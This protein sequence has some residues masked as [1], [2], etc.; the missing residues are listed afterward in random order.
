MP[1]DHA[2]ESDTVSWFRTSGSSGPISAGAKSSTSSTLANSKGSRRPK[3]ETPQAFRKPCALPSIQLRKCCVAMRL[4]FS[5][6]SQYRLL[7]KR[8]EHFG[9]CFRGLRR[10]VFVSSQ[11][12]LDIFWKRVFHGRGF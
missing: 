4:F 2:L 7:V 12:H 1:A 3:V 5:L 11:M 9:Q 6:S 10:K 8:L